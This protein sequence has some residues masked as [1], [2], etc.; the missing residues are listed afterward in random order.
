LRVIDHNSISSER[1]IFLQVGGSDKTYL[2]VSEVKLDEPKNLPA[3]KIELKKPL[4]PG[5]EQTVQ[6]PM[7]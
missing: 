3:W 5:S 7:S 2:R 4:A 6:A 1:S